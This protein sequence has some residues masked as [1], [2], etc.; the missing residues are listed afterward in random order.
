[1]KLHQL[2]LGLLVIWTT[3]HLRSSEQSRQC[4]Y[5]IPAP[6]FSNNQAP[7]YTLQ[8]STLQ[9]LINNYP[10]QYSSYNSY[11][12]CHPLLRP[13]PPTTYTMQQNLN[14][15]EKP[16][17]LYIEHTFAAYQGILTLKFL[18]DQTN[19]PANKHINE[20]CAILN[21]NINIYKKNNDT[22]INTLLA[23]LNIFQ[24]EGLKNLFKSF[25]S[26]TTIPTPINKQHQHNNLSKQTPSPLLT[27]TSPKLDMPKRIVT[28]RVIKKIKQINDPNNNIQ[29]L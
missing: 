20:C 1:M 23:E 10:L 19:T 29:A 5:N 27:N 12:L 13:T 7:L 9:H 16:D 25:Q 2:S 4:Y 8:S 21:K 14:T 3:S 15:S 18:L 11:P 6:H 28:K 24:T 26:I 17:A 22:Q